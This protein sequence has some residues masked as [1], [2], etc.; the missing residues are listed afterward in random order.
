MDSNSEDEDKLDLLSDA[1]ALELVEFDPAVEPEDAWEPPK[2]MASYLEKHFN[3]PLARAERMAIL[4][5]FPKPSCP[6][7]EVP[8]LDD[9]VRDHLKGRGKDPHFGAE[10]YLY[11]LQETVLDVT[12]HVP[13]GQP[14]G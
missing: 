14:L 7:L 8:K 9:Q 1:E 3:K 2:S 4:K 11:K 12:A 6:A 13:V 10:K 5:D